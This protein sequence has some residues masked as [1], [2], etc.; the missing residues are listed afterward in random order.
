[1][2]DNSVNC[3]TGIDLTTQGS[4]TVGNSS[5]YVYTTTNTSVSP[6]WVN[7]SSAVDAKALTVSGDAVFEGDLKIKG[8]SLTGVLE[9]IERRL[10]IL[11]VNPDLENRWRLLK[12][13]GDQY[14]EIEKDLLDKEKTWKVLKK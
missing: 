2:I 11:H 1:M 7:E 9:G 13:L 8:K 6:I 10:G 3:G 4:L 12:D 14:R 5:N